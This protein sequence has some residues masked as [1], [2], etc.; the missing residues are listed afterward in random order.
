M[1]FTI[2]VNGEDVWSTDLHV[3]QVS[4]QTAKG[5][6]GRIG[7]S[8]DANVVDIIVAEVAAGG[9]IRLDHLENLQARSL[10]GLR[11]GEV[12]G[13]VQSDRYQQE[14][15]MQG[16][17]G[18]QIYTAVPGNDGKGDP[19]ATFVGVDALEPTSGTTTADGEQLVGEDD[20][21]DPNN[22]ENSGLTQ[23][24]GS[25]EYVKTGDENEPAKT[26]ANTEGAPANSDATANEAEKF[27]LG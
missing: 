17:Q 22:V 3:D 25:G 5:E 9:P 2:R 21:T 23:N 26:D 10:A 27:E 4:M 12:A 14:D 16:T 18:D 6:A 1:S 8:Q 11:E 20:D 19:S 15:S 7:V 13:G 24:D